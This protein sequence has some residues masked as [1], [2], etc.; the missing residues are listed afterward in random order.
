M[1]ILVPESF[2]DLGK[3]NLTGEA[4]IPAPGTVAGPF[5]CAYRELGHGRNSL[6]AGIASPNT[7]LLHAVMVARRVSYPR[8]CL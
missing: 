3:A 5:R 7:V 2:F 1:R 4:Q 6:A 8:A